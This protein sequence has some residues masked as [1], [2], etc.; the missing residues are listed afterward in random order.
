ML[1]RKERQLCMDANTAMAEQLRIEF[2]FAL[3]DEQVLEVFTMNA[4]AS[5]ADAIGE[6]VIASRFPQQHIEALQAGIWGR[7]VDREHALADGDRV[8]LYR[9][10]QRDPRDARR[11]L[12]SSGMTMRGAEK[13]GGVR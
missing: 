10:L 13:A 1:L 2:V 7:P 9:P 4:G 12:A 6:S 5:V 11:D 8:E 3:A